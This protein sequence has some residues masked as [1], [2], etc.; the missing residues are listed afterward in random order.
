LLTHIPN[1]F[2]NFHELKSFGELHP[3]ELLVQL[4][5]IDVEFICQ[6]IAF[7]ESVHHWNLVSHIVVDNILFLLKLIIIKFENF[8]SQI[9]FNIVATLQV[10]ALKI[11]IG[12]EPHLGPITAEIISNIVRANVDHCLLQWDLYAETRSLLILLLL[13]LQHLGLSELCDILALRDI[14]CHIG[15]QTQLKLELFFKFVEA[16]LDIVLVIQV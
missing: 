2:V 9:E 8:A 6:I 5:S 13:F 15:I 10:G 4:C 7:G 3:E 11:R 16:D 1:D 14:G 12:V